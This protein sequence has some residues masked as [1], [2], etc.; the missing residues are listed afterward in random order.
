MFLFRYFF[1]ACLILFCYHPPLLTAAGG[2]SLAR[3]NML[4]HKV[5]TQAI[6]KVQ[7]RAIV[8]NNT[9][10]MVMPIADDLVPR[11]TEFDQLGVDFDP[12]YQS[13]L[14]YFDEKKLAFTK[15]HRDVQWQMVARAFNGIPNVEERFELIEAVRKYPFWRPLPPTAALGPTILIYWLH[16]KEDFLEELRRSAIEKR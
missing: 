12:E 5:V 10:E 8:R 11:E 13:I 16:A 7:P 2:I 9:K 15:S 3:S 1:Y 14:D 4:M 6:P